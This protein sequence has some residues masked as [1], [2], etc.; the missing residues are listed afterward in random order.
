MCRIAP[1][2][3]VG[4]SVYLIGGVRRDLLAGVCCSSSCLWH[5][6]QPKYRWRKKSGQRRKEI[7]D[8]QRSALQILCGVEM[9]ELYMSWWR[10]CSNMK[11][12]QMVNADNT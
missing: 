1:C 6:V 3:I 10:I 7:T 4:S 2:R 11:W 8:M 9:Y 5:S 12:C